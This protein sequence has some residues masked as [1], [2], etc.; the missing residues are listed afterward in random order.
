MTKQK[1]KISLIILLLFLSI[2]TA[3]YANTDNETSL[4]FIDYGEDI[5]CIRCI[6]SSSLSPEIIKESVKIYKEDKKGNT[7]VTD[8]S[9][10]KMKDGVWVAAFEHTEGWWIFSNTK[11]IA[12]PINVIELRSL[13]IVY[14]DDNN[15]KIRINRSK[16]APLSDLNRLKFNA[17]FE[18]GTVVIN[19]EGLNITILGDGK[20]IAVTYKLKNQEYIQIFDLNIASIVEIKAYKVDPSIILSNYP[21]P[22]AKDIRKGI[23]VE[24]IFSD[25]LISDISD[26]AITTVNE[27]EIT[28]KYNDIATAITLDRVEQIEASRIDDKVTLTSFPKPSKEAIINVLR[29]YALYSN[30]A[31]K[32]I[33]D[34][35][36]ISIKENNI[37]FDFA[38]KE[39]EYPLVRL[40][41]IEAARLDNNVILSDFPVLTEEQLKERICVEAFYS[42]GTKNIV[43]SDTFIEIE[44]NCAQIHYGEQATKLYLDCLEKIEATR[45]NDQVMLLNFPVSI[46]DIQENISVVAVYSNGSRVNVTDAVI[47]KVMD[48][49]AEIS[50]ENK[51]TQIKMDILEEIKVN[52]KNGD[53][54]KTVNSTIQSEEIRKRISAVACYSNGYQVDISEVVAIRQIDQ[55]TV[56]FRYGNL[57][58]NKVLFEDR[59]KQNSNF[60][61]FIKI[62][63]SVLLIA[64]I[65]LSYFIIWNKRKLKKA[66]DE[67]DKRR[68]E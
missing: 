1:N 44:G 40:E 23:K 11:E 22:S 48:N 14:P 56:E 2:C 47:I 60:I 34:L 16:I 36:E 54:L 55:C 38:G 62:S 46:K 24:A 51:K 57:F 26:K 15:T 17:I 58:Y 4:Y 27:N 7:D 33:T 28:V 65:V 30:G 13:E 18:D 35:V 9:S 3:C 61:L 45:L 68:L 6:N 21:R 52:T 10:I 63:I 25:G 41:R 39:T 66:I 8:V 5:D 20:Q 37:V 29:V 49:K 32:D 53:L 59:S 43:T 50:F 64:I 12:I 19:P 31:K 42:N 67:I